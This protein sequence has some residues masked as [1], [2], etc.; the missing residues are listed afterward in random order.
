MAT[1]NLY[2]VK[3][4]LEEARVYE[5]TA[6][7]LFARRTKESMSQGRLL[8]GK[9]IRLEHQAENLYAEIVGVHMH[10]KDLCDLFG[11]TGGEALWLLYLKTHLNFQQWNTTPKP[12]H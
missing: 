10:H 8:F 1:K 4:L 2:K 11:I 6:R 3:N 9:A 12:I 7:G 5:N